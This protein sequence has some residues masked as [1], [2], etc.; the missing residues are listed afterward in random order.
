MSVFKRQVILSLTATSAL[1]HRSCLL[2]C[3][4][5]IVSA[6]AL[7]SRQGHIRSLCHADIRPELL[8]R[9][10]V[11]CRKVTAVIWWLYC[12]PHLSLLILILIDLLLLNERV[13]VPVRGL[14]DRKH[15]DSAVIQI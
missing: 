7:L 6:F 2:I 9:R 13:M 4:G 15:L 12:H 1:V 10:V 14:M 11:P 8:K 5:V 3:R